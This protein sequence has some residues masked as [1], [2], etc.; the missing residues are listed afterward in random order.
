MDVQSAEEMPHRLALPE[1]ISRVLV[2]PAHHMQVSMITSTP[3][4]YAIAP[5][6]R[7]NDAGR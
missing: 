4:H 1:I 3:A 5:G 2:S 6:V 7:F